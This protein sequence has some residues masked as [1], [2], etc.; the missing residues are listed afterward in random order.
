MTRERI[1][2]E[3]LEA[4]GEVVPGAREAAIDPKLLLR[5]QI[6][7]DSM[8]FLNFVLA[9]EARFSIEVPPTSYPLFA[10]VERA[11]DCVAELLNAKP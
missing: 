5:T 11:V 6:E 4:L 3:V 7:I 2:D 1:E 9:L 8:D 10:T